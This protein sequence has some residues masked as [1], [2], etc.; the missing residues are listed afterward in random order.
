MAPRRQRQDD[1][2][3]AH[4]DAGLPG[5]QGPEDVVQHGGG[6]AREG[7]ELR[8]GGGRQRDPGKLCPAGRGD[9]RGGE[10][11]VPVAQGRH[12]HPRQ[13]RHAPR[14]APVVAA[15]E[16]PRRYVQMRTTSIVSIT[17]SPGLCIMTHLAVHYYTKERTSL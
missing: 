7:G 13:P 14:A 15:Q 5:P 11:P 2:G 10:P 17:T 9:H 12:P 3:T 4:A 6:D 1:P 16:D 8:R